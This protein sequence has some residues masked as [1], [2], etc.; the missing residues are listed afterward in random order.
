MKNHIAI[1]FFAFYLT[2]QYSY[3]QSRKINDLKE[4][5][6]ENTIQIINGKKY[7]LHKWENT[8]A[9]SYHI[10]GKFDYVSK[11]EWSKFIKK[12]ED[13]TGLKIDRT[14]NFSEANIHI[15]FGEFKSYFNTF[16]INS[17]LHLVKNFDSWSSRKYSR[18]NQ[19]IAT[20]S[21]CIVPSKTKSKK[22][23]NY[24]VK[25]LFLK[26]LGMLGKSKSEYS[27]LYKHQTDSNSR[28]SK[29]DKRTL[30]LHY[31]PAIKSGMNAIEAK[32]IL[33]SSIDLAELIKEKI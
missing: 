4:K 28:L 16:K 8:E 11:K 32:K 14:E 19:Q 18:T 24:N 15:Y 10:T 20:A 26:S 12:I 21:Y 5:Y 13:L 29:S 33:N 25:K 30:K 6:I 17:P 3:S 22:R 7:P 23:G 2:T 31:N 1:I 27:I 9:I